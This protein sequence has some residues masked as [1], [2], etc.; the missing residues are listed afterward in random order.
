MKRKKIKRKM[1][2]IFIIYLVFG[3]TLIDNVGKTMYQIY[4]K[5]K[6]KKEFENQLIELKDKEEELKATVTK[7]QDPDYVARY[8][9]EKY[10][11]SK[12]GEIII[13]IPD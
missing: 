3:I 12:D 9:R 13:R 10:L 6:E 2:I 11:Y 1:L 8:A 4:Q 7:L 5:S